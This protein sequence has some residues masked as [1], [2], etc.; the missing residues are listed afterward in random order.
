MVIVGAGGHAKEVFD[1]LQLEKWNS[2]E[3]I[4]FFDDINKETKTLLG[5][6]IIHN[7]K[8]IHPGCQLILAIGGTNARKKLYKKIV[9]NFLS[10]KWIN[11][12]APNASVAKTDITLGNALNIMQFVVISSSVK[13]GNG[14]L[15]NAGSKI[16]HD[17]S[18]GEFC[19]ICPM[20]TITGGCQIGDEVFIGTGATVLPN[21]KVGNKV[22]IGAGAVVTKD[23]PEGATAVGIPAKII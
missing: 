1:V 9:D 22:K 14:T 20:V 18:I 13:I 21:V 19:E 17:V 10:T 15:I 6:K 4:Y 3:K 23:V 8:E 7:L 16:H 11:L 5:I 2:S 12:I